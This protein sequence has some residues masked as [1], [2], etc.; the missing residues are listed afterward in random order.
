MID[1]I[2]L[3]LV[4]I[5]GFYNEKKIEA[6]LS[7]KYSIE[8]TSKEF[9]KIEKEKNYL[10]RLWGEYISD[11]YALVGKNGSGKTQI[12]K[13][14]MDIFAGERDKRIDK[15]DDLIIVYEDIEK[16]ELLY[17][18]EQSVNLENVDEI[19]IK[20]IDK[21]KCKELY[22]TYKIAYTH[23]VLTLDDYLNSE[24][25]KYNF[26]VGGMIQQNFMQKKKVY[27]ENTE[28]DKIVD[29]FAEHDFKIINF[30]YNRDIIMEME[31]IFPFPQYIHISTSQIKSRIEFDNVVKE[32]RWAIGTE[33]G[34][35]ER[36]YA[37]EQN[38]DKILSNCA[39]KWIANLIKS[40]ILD[41]LID[42]SIPQTIP[43]NRYNYDYD[44]VWNI[45]SKADKRRL[46]KDI[47]TEIIDGINKINDIKCEKY[48]NF[49][50]WIRDNNSQITKYES[51]RLEEIK[52]PI[53]E[54]TDIFVK[55]L[56]EHCKKIGF[57]VP[58]LEFKFDIS[59][60]EY[61]FLSLFAD[62]HSMNLN[63]EKSNRKNFLLLLDEPDVT[64]HPRWQRNF[65]FWLM[66]FINNYFCGCNVQIIITTHSPIL[67][68]DFPSQNVLYLKQN[69]DEKSGIKGEKNIARR[70]FG[71]NIHTLFLDS[72]FLE[73]E[74]T[75]GRFAEIQINKLIDNLLHNKENKNIND[76]IIQYVECIGDELIRGKLEKLISSQSSEISSYIKSDQEMHTKAL[77]LLKKQKEELEVLI[78]H[79]ETK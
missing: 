23:G 16:E 20:R 75:M 33:E 61:A 39:S 6:L 43:N 27:F 63:N 68:S 66:K 57:R 18:S 10:C 35:L 73:D 44:F 22:D 71:C 60:G 13:F 34:Q 19:T 7:G 51:E 69:K 48:L 8:M 17:Y 79:W 1:N 52:I 67:L 76:E 32:I 45:F 49:L 41:C 46:K 55:E 15:Y 12:M 29:Y 56:I 42:I 24:C 65:V 5:Y 3:Q 77:D 59:S 26:S 30:L 37:F 53:S 62:L 58:A 72:F 38:V 70:T 31:N 4:Y 14:I 2:K 54:E 25:V 74:G 28:S 40:I 9:L 64:M 21:E 36:I 11:C 47:F 50:K 78:N